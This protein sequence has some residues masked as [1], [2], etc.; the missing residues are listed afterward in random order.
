MVLMG[1]LAAHAGPLLKARES[2]RHALAHIED[3]NKAP[4]YKNK[5]KGHGGKCEEKVRAAL[6]QVEEAIAVAEENRD[7]KR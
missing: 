6:K 1:A 2:L 5:L 4:E 3:A 7:A